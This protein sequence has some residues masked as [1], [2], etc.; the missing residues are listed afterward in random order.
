MGDVTA[1]FTIAITGAAGFIGHHTVDAAIKRGCNIAAIVRP[2]SSVPN[3]WNASDRITVHE[4]DLTNHQDKD[5]LARVVSECKAVI[6]AAASLYGDDAAQRSTTLQANDNLLEAFSHTE[7][8]HPALVLVSSLAVYDTYSLSENAVV[9]ERTPLA[10]SA[11]DRD[12][13][14]RAKLA[15]EEAVLRAA[16][17]L[18]LQVRI[19][20]PGAVFGSGNLWN[21]HIGPAAGPIA[22]Q[23][24]HEGEVPTC[25]V[26]HCADALVLAAT[27]PITQDDRTDPSGTGRV[28]FI[29]IVDDDRPT[30]NDFLV[31]MRK[32]GWPKIVLPGTWRALAVGGKV[33]K[34]I[35]LGRKAPG[36]LRPA[37]L[38]ARI[39]PLRYC[40][41]RLRSRLSWQ[42]TAT[43]EEA[44]RSSSAMEA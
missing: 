35:G 12:A 11:A 29:N 36:L 38:H 21:G 42:A 41:Q 7:A 39:K 34:T 24:A 1:P 14:C 10:G 9:T 44:M 16:T 32:T 25:F 30:R 31:E 43:F 6:H 13:Y 40:N 27:K 18:D 28:E 20:R 5:K 19:M 33:L 26:E 23:L 4:L 22:V 3:D 17:Q 8:P 15:Q 37:V 2:G